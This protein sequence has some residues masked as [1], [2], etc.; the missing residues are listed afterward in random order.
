LPSD[1]ENTWYW[2]R[3]SA[4]VFIAMSIPRPLRAEVSK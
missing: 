4:I 3:F 1:A 2:T